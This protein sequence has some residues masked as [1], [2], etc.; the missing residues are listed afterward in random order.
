MAYCSGSD[1]MLPQHVLIP[2]R[3]FYPPEV[4]VQV[5]LPFMGG[6][7]EDAGYQVLDI[8]KLYPFCVHRQGLFQQFLP[9]VLGDDVEV[10]EL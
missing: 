5:V 9:L 7:E 4:S 2:C 1:G 10:R 8:F 3:I 6:D